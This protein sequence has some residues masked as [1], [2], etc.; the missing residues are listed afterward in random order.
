MAPSPK[1]SGGK[2]KAG[3]AAVA[4]VEA[5][6]QQ[7]RVLQTRSQK[8]GLQVRLHASFHATFTHRDFYFP[9]WLSRD[10]VPCGTYPPLPQATYAAQHSHRR[11]GGGVHERD[12]GVFDR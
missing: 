6:A 9:L 10:V 12:L 4:P 2:S 3:S 11:E 7:Q 8:A 5:P 1:K